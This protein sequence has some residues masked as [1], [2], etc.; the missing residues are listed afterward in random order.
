MHKYQPRI[1]VIRTA[2]LA[3]IPWAPQQ[4]F[5]FPETEFVA[6][7]AYQVR[8]HYFWKMNL[9]RCFHD[10]NKKQKK[11]KQKQNVYKQVI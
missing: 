7:T 5:V 3:Q 10:K 8:T 4:G 6:V 9:F 2:D 11:R 1:H